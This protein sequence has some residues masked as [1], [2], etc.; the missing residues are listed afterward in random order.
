MCAGT[1]PVR[2]TVAICSAVSLLAL[3]GFSGKE[4]VSLW[5]SEEYGQNV[6]RGARRGLLSYLVLYIS[7]LAYYLAL[8]VSLANSAPTPRWMTPTQDPRTVALALGAVPLTFASLLANECKWVLATWVPPNFRRRAALEQDGAEVWALRCMAIISG[9]TFSVM[10]ALN[11]GDGWS[12][13]LGVTL[14]FLAVAASLAPSTAMPQEA[15]GEQL[16]QLNARR[17]SIEVI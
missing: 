14:A 7:P 11:W 8:I 12:L 13:T 3:G 1:T 16:Q 2:K 9:V 17:P 6:G 10:A 4:V 15:R 5:R